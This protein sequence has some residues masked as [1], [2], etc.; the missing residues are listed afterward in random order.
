M[1]ELY[2]CL[3]CW[4]VYDSIQVTIGPME[5]CGCGSRRFKSTFPGKITTI[6]RFLTDPKY[7]ILG[8]RIYDKKAS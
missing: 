3:D 5:T 4:R 8:E 1:S 7:M 6:K 2:K